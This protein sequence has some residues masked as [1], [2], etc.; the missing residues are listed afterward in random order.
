MKKLIHYQEGIIC[1]LQRDTVRKIWMINRSLPLLPK[2]QLHAS[3]GKTYRHG[4]PKRWRLWHLGGK[5]IRDTLGTHIYWFL[6]SCVP[7]LVLLPFS[8][9]YRCRNSL[10]FKVPSRFL[11]NTVKLCFKSFLNFFLLNFLSQPRL[12]RHCRNSVLFSFLFLLTSNWSNKLRASFWVQISPRRTLTPVLR[13]HCDGA[14]KSSGWRVVCA[15][16]GVWVCV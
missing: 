9:V 5:C 3:T 13:V 4:P 16:M 15:C 2:G 6:T 11:S 1:C 8:T 10:K 12:T 14:A 7:Q